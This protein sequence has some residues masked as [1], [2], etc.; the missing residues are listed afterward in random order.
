ML[1]FD[2]LSSHEIIPGFVGKFVHTDSMTIGRFEIAEG[3]VLPSH[4]HIHEQVSQ[5]LDGLF[6][7]TI[8][9]VVQVYKKGMVA[10]IPSN[11]VHSGRAIV[12]CVVMDIFVPVREDYNF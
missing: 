4:S 11:V 10:V 9:G 3:A 2:H 6:E 7:L 5:V 8:D 12:N 1:H